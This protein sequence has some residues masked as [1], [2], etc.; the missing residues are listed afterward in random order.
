M[1]KKDLI[2][3]SVVGVGVIILAFVI[4]GNVKKKPS[5]ALIAGALKP[6]D[7]VSKTEPNKKTVF[8]DDEKIK[9][10]IDRANKEWGRDPFSIFLDQEYQIREFKLQGISV[11][12]DGKK[13]YAFINDAI[14]SKGEKIG[15]YE[16]LDIRKDRVLLKK[17][18]Q[19]F[20]LT[21][22]AE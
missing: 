12:K 13:N 6:K 21:F 7:T 14:V 3:L 10:Q 2:Q 18:D 1:S 16:I 20:Y 8:A 4:M 5:A 11:G 22:P 19:S 9:N 17:G 15:A